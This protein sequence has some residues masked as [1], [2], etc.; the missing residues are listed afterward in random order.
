MSESYGGPEDGFITPPNPL[1]RPAPPVQREIPPAVRPGMTILVQLRKPM[2]G[3]A[4]LERPVPMTVHTPEMCRP[5]SQTEVS[6]LVDDDEVEPHSITVCPSCIFA[7]AKDYYVTLGE[8][9]VDYKEFRE[10]Q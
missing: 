4:H 1:E 6:F 2:F 7:W 9:P 10:A 5:T 3:N 8:G